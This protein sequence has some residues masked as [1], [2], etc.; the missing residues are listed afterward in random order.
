MDTCAID[1]PRPPPKGSCKRPSSRGAPPLA[2]PLR[3]HGP[4]GGGAGR[5]GTLAER[6]VLCGRGIW[7]ANP[8][9]SNLCPPTPREGGMCACGSPSTRAEMFRLAAPHPT[10]MVGGAREGG[11]RSKSQGQFIAS[12]HSK[13]SA[14]TAV[15]VGRVQLDPRR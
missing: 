6:R 13:R 10:H 14:A 3:R 15:W 1:Q 11:D 7:A 4:A 5:A 12:L 9:C 2:G 8:T